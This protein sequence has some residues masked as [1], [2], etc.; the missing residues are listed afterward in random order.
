[1]VVTEVLVNGFGKYLGRDFPGHPGVKN[2]PASAGDMGLM[3][4]LGRFHALENS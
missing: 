3:P 4:G 1:M 2:L